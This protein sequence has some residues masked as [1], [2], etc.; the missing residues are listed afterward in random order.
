[1]APPAR[2]TR[3]KPVLAGLI[4]VVLLIAAAT[5]WVAWPRT[6]VAA[7]GVTLGALGRGISRSNLNVVLLTLDTLRADHLGAYGNTEVRTPNLDTLA[8]EGAV[9]EQAMTSAPLTLPAHSSIM[10]GQFP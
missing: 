2:Q 4:G 3:R 1:M 5:A 9:F 10:T 8:R 7:G 6:Q